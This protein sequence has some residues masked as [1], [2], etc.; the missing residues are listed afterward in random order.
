MTEWLASHNGLLLKIKVSLVESNSSLLLCLQLHTKAMDHTRTCLLLKLCLFLVGIRQWQIISLVL[1][2]L[3]NKYQLRCITKAY[4][5]SINSSLSKLSRLTAIKCTWFKALM[6]RSAISRTTLKT[7][8]TCRRS[9]QRSK[10]PLARARLSTWRQTIQI[11]M[12]QH[13]IDPS[14]SLLT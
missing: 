7:V 8:T 6:S 2:S 5:Q 11:C 9:S 13:A 12:R 1:Y 4:N 3:I 14:K 10:Q